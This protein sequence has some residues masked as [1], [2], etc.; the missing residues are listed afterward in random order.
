MAFGATG[1]IAL[2]PVDLEKNEE[3]GSVQGMRRKIANILV[4]SSSLKGVMNLYVVSM[5]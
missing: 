2:K 5:L 4:T 3:S 1:L